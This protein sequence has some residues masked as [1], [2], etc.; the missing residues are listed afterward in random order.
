M[1]FLKFVVCVLTIFTLL[2]FS[3]GYLNEHDVISKQL[4]GIDIDNIAIDLLKIKAFDKLKNPS[5]TDLKHISQNVL[6]KNM[7]VNKSNLIYE[8]EKAIDFDNDFINLKDKKFNVVLSNPPY[9][10]LKINKKGKNK[11]LYI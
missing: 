5:I 9:F 3:Y 2:I 10:L 11:R 1:K 7:L 4:Y 6:C 8:D